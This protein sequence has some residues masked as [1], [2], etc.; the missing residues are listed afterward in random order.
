MSAGFS[1]VYDFSEMPF[2]SKDFRLMRIRLVERTPVLDA[3][4]IRAPFFRLGIYFLL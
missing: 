4:L 1:L 2:P 3:R